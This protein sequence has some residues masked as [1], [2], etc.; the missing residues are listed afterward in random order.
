MEYI[1]SVNIRVFPSSFRKQG[2]DPES[3]L[4]T[5]ANL[6]APGVIG[7]QFENYVVGYDT[8]ESTKNI[9]K[10]KFVLGG[11]YFELKGNDINRIKDKWLFIKLRDADITEENGAYTTKIL[12]SWDEE[13]SE[14]LDNDGGW[15]T[16]IAIEE[17]NTKDGASFG[18]KLIDDEGKINETALLPELRHGKGE[19]SLTITNNDSENASGSYSIASFGCVASGEK[20]IALG[21]NTIADKSNLTVV[22]QFNSTEDGDL[23]VVGNG[24]ANESRGNVL[25]VNA[26][27][28]NINKE[29]NIAGNVTISGTETVTGDVTVNGSEKIAGDFNVN[30]KF[31]AASESGNTTIKGTLD[32]AKNLK[33]N[34]DKFE[35]TAS[36]GNTEIKG[37]LKAGATTI[38]GTESVSGD[39][40]VN[41]NKF[42]VTAANGNTSIAGTLSV[43]K[44]T[45]LSNGLDVTN[46][47]DLSNTNIVGSLIVK[48]NKEDTE[49]FKVFDNGTTI[50]YNN[51][52]YSTKTESDKITESAA[53]TV[54]GGA[55]VKQD[56]HVGKT[57]KTDNININNETINISTESS[58]TRLTVADN[59]ELGD[60]VNA[61]LKKILL[62][63]AYP[64]GSVY[65]YSGDGKDLESEQVYNDGST[66]KVN[67]N[68]TDTT[69]EQAKCPIK[70]TLGGTWLQIEERFLYAGKCNA[71]EDNYK[72]DDKDGSKN[73][74]AIEHTH[75]L[76]CDSS[77]LTISKTNHLHGTLYT[78]RGENSRGLHAVSTDGGKTHDCNAEDGII[79]VT[80]GYKD[81]PIPEV[82]FT[83]KEVQ[84][85]PY[86]D[87]QPDRIRF[88]V[89]HDHSVNPHN[90]IVKQTDNGGEDGTNKNMPPYLV[91]YMWKRMPDEKT[92]ED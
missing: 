10:I 19:H 20:S 16:G 22:G 54:E 74:V 11:Y 78:G 4:N 68:G 49:K 12:D 23:F 91:V 83:M 25:Q 32:V 2:I 61:G 14:L 82:K 40:S 67:P 85:R 69:H 86:Q 92:D 5:E 52:D 39:F 79:K 80:S 65:V 27:K 60:S 55:N 21:D 66:S 3:E 43:T 6:I 41:T 50:V 89:N 48:A 46:A 77:S 9:T 1:S 53:F 73:A 62:D 88:D 18:I 8:D 63:L 26:S 59:F 71:T 30:D 56:L 70:K 64:V 13:T 37:T 90:H 76:S 45:T 36:N 81:Y 38:S 75:T 17:L 72:L 87:H 33:V 44:K 7:N 34:S 57:L 42:K 35:V 58:K 47:S 24:L 15:F 31:I 84:I 29:T 28:V 51:T